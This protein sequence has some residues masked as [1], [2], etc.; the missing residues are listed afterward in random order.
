MGYET[1]FTLKLAFQIQEG[2]AIWENKWEKM[3]SKK[4]V[5]N[6]H[7]IFLSKVLEKLIKGSDEL[8]MKL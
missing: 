3:N 1:K 6:R 7:K 5:S 4:L 2:S 8:T